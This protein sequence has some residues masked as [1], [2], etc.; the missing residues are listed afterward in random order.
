VST[1]SGTTA[2][3]PGAF[4]VQGGAVTVIPERLVAFEAVTVTPESC[5]DF[6][7]VSVED[8]GDCARALAVARIDATATKV[9]APLDINCD[10]A[11]IQTPSR[12]EDW[13]AQRL[14]A[15]F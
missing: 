5:V 13:I 8:G 15:Y 3:P 14:H 2:F 7:A 1:T 12:K 4:T 9:A 6:G 10:M 11:M